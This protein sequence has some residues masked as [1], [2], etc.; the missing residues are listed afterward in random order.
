MNF[1]KYIDK[2]GLNINKLFIN[3]S[4]KRFYLTVQYWYKGTATRLRRS[5]FLTILLIYLSFHEKGD[6]EFIG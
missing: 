6:L 3:L 2:I 5:L 1:L 4:Q